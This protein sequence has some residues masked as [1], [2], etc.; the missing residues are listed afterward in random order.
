MWGGS[1]AHPQQFPVGGAKDTE[2]AIEGVPDRS[3][4]ETAPICTEWKCL[5]PR[6]AGQ[7]TVRGRNVG[8][9]GRTGKQRA[10]P[11]DGGAQRVRIFNGAR[12]GTRV[13]VFE[14]DL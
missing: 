11:E 4:K 13:S 9:Q 10:L 3:Q 5:R 14:I 6:G 2:K 12:L 7:G 8:K 1:A